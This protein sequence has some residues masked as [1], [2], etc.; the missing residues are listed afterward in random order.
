MSQ[1]ISIAA[2]ARER[3]GKG[4]ARATRR[5][6]RVPAVIYGNKQDPV[7]ISLDPVELN[8]QLDG[9]GFFSR[10]FEV[11]VAGNKHKVLA[12]DLQLDPVSDRPI[13]VDFM[14][15]SATTRINI[16]VAMVF[17]NEEDSPGLKRGGVLN[18]VRHTVEMLCAPDSIP[19]QIELD[20][21]G[22]EIGDSIHASVLELPEGVELIISDRDF[23]IATIAAP[24]I[25]TVEEEEEGEEGE[26]EE[27]AE[28]T[29]AEAEE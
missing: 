18:I 15:F 12:R 9:P 17:V 10:V 7:M 11:S 2:E 5:A 19:E 6:G 28:D 3:A 8:R 1:V 13:H 25:M 22:L 16:D 14:R 4:A 23:T 20:L 26:E 27:A 29:E 21:T 24:T